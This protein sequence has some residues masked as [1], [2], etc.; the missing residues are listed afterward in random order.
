MDIVIFD[1]VVIPAREVVFTASRSQGPGGQHVNK[2]NS[3]ITLHFDIQAS[4]SLTDFQK[5]RLQQAFPTRITSEGILRLHCQMHRG[6]SMNRAELIDR[7]AELCRRA[8][9]P[10]RT[11]V[12]T[13]V[14]RSAKER[15]LEQK[16]QRGQTKR[17][18]SGV[19]MQDE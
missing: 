10:K 18:R 4:C 13:K 15:R 14:S 8:L 11:R 9:V 16:K 17:K 12:P 1:K 19:S 7:F 3:R 5:R 6:Q 2:V